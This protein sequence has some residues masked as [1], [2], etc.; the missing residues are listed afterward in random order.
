MKRRWGSL[1][2]GCVCGAVVGV[3]LAWHHLHGA[4]MS[5]THVPIPASASTAV[6][7][8]AVHDIT[9][10]DELTRLAQAHPTGVLIDF[11]AQWC[12]PCQELAPRLERLAQHHPQL[13][14]AAVDAATYPKLA[15]AFNVDALPALVHLIH[16]QEVARQVG[17]PSEAELTAWLGLAPLAPAAPSSAAPGSSGH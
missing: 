5:D 15:D 4:G 9:S 1:V 14:V 8:S 16:G 7:A 6:A 10:L 2:L 17:A 13:A 3:F 11:H 12:V